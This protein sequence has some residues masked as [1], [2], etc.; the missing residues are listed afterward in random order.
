MRSVHIRLSEKCFEFARTFSLFC[1]GRGVPC[2]GK[3]ANFYRPAIFFLFKKKKLVQESGIQWE[4]WICQFVH[5][6][7]DV[8]S[9]EVFKQLNEAAFRDIAVQYMYSSRNTCSMCFF[10][11]FHDRRH[12]SEMSHHEHLYQQQQSLL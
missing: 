1:I 7:R 10:S 12:L 9:C 2:R 6:I 3:L 4:F 11:F 5:L 8:W